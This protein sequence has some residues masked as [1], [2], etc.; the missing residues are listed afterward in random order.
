LEFDFAVRG[1]GGAR[2]FDVAF[3]DRR[4]GGHDLLRVWFICFEW[5]G[6]FGVAKVVGVLYTER[7]E[8][9]R[10]VGKARWCRP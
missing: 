9:R 3:E 10:S 5:F 7:Q 2:A 6:S 1:G 4:A 8:T